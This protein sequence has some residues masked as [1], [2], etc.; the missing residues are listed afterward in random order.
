M[1]QFSY[2]KSNL[3]NNQHHHHHHVFMIFFSSIFFWLTFDSIG[4]DIKQK[5]LNS[6][7]ISGDDNKTN[8]QFQLKF[9]DIQDFGDIYRCF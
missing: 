7:M 1:N 8:V 4:C 9:V 2:F 3:P 6:T 5:K